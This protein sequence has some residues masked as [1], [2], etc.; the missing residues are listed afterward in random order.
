MNLFILGTLELPTSKLHQDKQTRQWFD[1]SLNKQNN[2]KLLKCDYNEVGLRWAWMPFDELMM[3]H[4]MTNVIIVGRASLLPLAHCTGAQHNQA[5]QPSMPSLQCPKCNDVQVGAAV[6]TS[7]MIKITKSRLY[8]GLVVV[9][10]LWQS[11]ASSILN[12]TLII[13]TDA[14]DA[15]AILVGLSAIQSCSQKVLYL[16]NL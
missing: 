2:I 9:Q 8:M 1:A 14:A 4:L 13:K 10:L 6:R 12:S 5:T 7:R 3:G 16:L 15:Q 11:Q